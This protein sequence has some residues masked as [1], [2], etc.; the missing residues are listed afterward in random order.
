[1]FYVIIGGLDVATQLR[2]KGCMHWAELLFLNN[3]VW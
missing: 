2:E 3:H 1:M